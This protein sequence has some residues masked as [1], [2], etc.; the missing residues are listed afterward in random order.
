MVQI[1]GCAAPLCCSVVL[2]APTADL[3]HECDR[4][5]HDALSVLLVVRQD[6]KVVGAAGSVE[7]AVSAR[8]R[9]HARA[10]R[11]VEQHG[12][13][14]LADAL[15]VIPSTVARN[16]CLDV[17]SLIADASAQHVDG[18]NP[19]V[20]IDVVQGV[21]RDVV[22]GSPQVMAPARLTQS[23]LTL[24]CN[25]A[26]QILRIDENVMMPPRESFVVTQ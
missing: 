11:S 23:I 9:Q 13:R 15:E 6:L 25:V 17:A 7:L 22:S 2:V 1:S 19:T 21:V 3:L 12:C 18:A 14:V 20:G 4:S 26:I 10:V 24:A 16:A 8:L 5:L